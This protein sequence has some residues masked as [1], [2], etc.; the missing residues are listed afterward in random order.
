MIM[1]QCRSLSKVT[2]TRLTAAIAIPSYIASSGLKK[3]SLD[4]SGAIFGI[5]V[6]FVL[7]ISRWPFLW[8]LLVFFVTSSKATK[9]R[10]HIKKKIE[11]DDFKPGGQRNW[12][13]VI[14]NGGVAVFMAIQYL[15]VVGLEQVC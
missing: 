10:Q 7:S 11:G 15:H 5:V 13:Q 14:C 12:I 6:A 9:Y 4:L 1:R 3:Q 2:S 8:A